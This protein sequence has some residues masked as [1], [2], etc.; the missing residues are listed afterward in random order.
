MESEER[1]PQINV[2]VDRD[3]LEVLQHA[4]RLAWPHL[5]LRTGKILLSLAGWKAKEIIEEH[6]KEQHLQHVKRGR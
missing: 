4:A 5:R 1:K 6:L 3:E 2:R